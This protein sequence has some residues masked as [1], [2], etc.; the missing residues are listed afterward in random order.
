MK[1]YATERF[2][3]CFNDLPASIQKQAKEAFKTKTNHELGVVNL[4]QTSILPNIT[5]E[6]KEESKMD[7][8][9]NESSSDSWKFLEPL[10]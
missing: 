10:R 8:S 5:S 6:I 1:S 7:F 3:K 4:L 9:R 2:W